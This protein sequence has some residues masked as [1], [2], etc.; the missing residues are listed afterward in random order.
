MKRERDWFGSNNLFRKVNKKTND[1][2]GSE[3]TAKK[4]DLLEPKLEDKD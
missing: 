3:N 1:I 4:Y 2:N